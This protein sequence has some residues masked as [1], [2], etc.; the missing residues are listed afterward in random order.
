MWKQCFTVKEGDLNC[1][2]V[3]K[4]NFGI[5]L[6]KENEETLAKSQLFEILLNEK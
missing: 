3:A 5:E 6:I 2:I 4:A 1:F